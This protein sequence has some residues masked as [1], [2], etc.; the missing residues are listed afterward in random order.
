MGG[1]EKKKLCKLSD[2]KFP[3]K[4]FE[5]Y[6][7][8]VAAPQFICAKCGRAAVSQKNLCKPKQIGSV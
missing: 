1:Y 6:A 2:K 7:A 5:K 3:E 4:K 8:L